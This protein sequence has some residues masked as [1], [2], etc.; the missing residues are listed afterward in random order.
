MEAPCTTV[1]ADETRR[2]KNA[3][4]AELALS[5]NVTG[6]SKAAGVGRAT[7][8]EWKEKDDAFL[9]AFKQAELAA[10][11]VLEREARRRAL[12]YELEQ[13]GKNGEIQRV[14]RYS[15]LLLIFL[16]KGAA[17]EKYRDNVNVTHVS[18]TVRAYAD[19]DPSKM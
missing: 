8:Y 4:L 5:G 6:A 7:V 18:E 14:R 13:I 17:P 15:D 2:A 16:L 10:V 9:V 1:A 3:F 19:F 12:G 11:D